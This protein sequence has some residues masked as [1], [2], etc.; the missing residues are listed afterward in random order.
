MEE[1]RINALY[2]ISEWDHNNWLEWKIPTI[3]KNLKGQWEKLKSHLTGVA[4]IN[5]EEHDDFVWD[6]NGRE[7]TVK[8]WYNVLQ[9]KQNQQD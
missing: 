6:P 9:E 8:S 5:R 2:S 3:P 4:P 7:Y 1:R